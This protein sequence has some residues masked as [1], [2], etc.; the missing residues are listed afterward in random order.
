MPK[1]TCG[2]IKSLDPDEAL[3]SAAIEALLAGPTAAEH[4]EGLT[5]WFSADTEGALNGVTVDDQGAAVVDFANF[6][7]AI[8]NAST[9]AGR[10]QLLSELRAT[11]FQFDFVE[12]AEIQFDGNCGEFWIWLGAVCTPLTPADT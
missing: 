1:A 11:I 3:L 6:S 4:E 8:P 5:S 10:L 7:A 2:P 12:S 9:T